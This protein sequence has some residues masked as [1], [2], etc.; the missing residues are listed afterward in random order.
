MVKV[1]VAEEDIRIVTSNMA[2]ARR[3][4]GNIDEAMCY[5]LREIKDPNLEIVSWSNRYKMIQM[6]PRND[7]EKEISDILNRK[8]V[9]HRKFTDAEWE[10]MKDQIKDRIF[11]QAVN[12]QRQKNN[13]E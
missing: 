4:H 2:L 1:Y 9:V 10:E 13:K 8:G 11:Y 3:S 5:V 12:A 6:N 7:L